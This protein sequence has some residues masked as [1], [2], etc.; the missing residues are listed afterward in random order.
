MKYYTRGISRL[1]D[2]GKC[3]L[4]VVY[5]AEHGLFVNKIC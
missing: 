3:S 4:C 2:L 1:A 5:W